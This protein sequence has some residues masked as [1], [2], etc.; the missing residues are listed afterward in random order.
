MP[1]YDYKCK[2]CNKTITVTKLMSEVSRDE[3]C[4][5]CNEIMQ[6]IFTPVGNKWNCS[7]AYDGKLK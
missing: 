7:G 6:R 5:E 1:N 3:K 4:P 2:K